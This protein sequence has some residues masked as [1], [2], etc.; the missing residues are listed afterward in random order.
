MCPRERD[1]SILR[2]LTIRQTVEF[3]HTHM[4]KALEHHQ[5]KLISF[6]HSGLGQYDNICYE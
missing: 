6:Y 5:H 2:I 3:E 4:D 1:V